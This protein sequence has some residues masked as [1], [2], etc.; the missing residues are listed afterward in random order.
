[1]RDLKI[2]TNEN[3][4][5]LLVT[6]LKNSLQCM[7]GGPLRDLLEK[8]MSI[9]TSLGAEYL[10]LRAQKIEKTE[11]LLKENK[12]EISTGIL[13]GIGIRALVGGRWGFSSVTKLDSIESGIKEAISMA[14]AS[15]KKGSI[16]LEEVPTVE[17]SVTVGRKVDLDPRAVTPEE[18]VSV[19]G[20]M[21]NK[22][23]GI[24]GVKAV[25]I[26][27]LD[28]SGRQYFCNSEG[29]YIEEDKTYVWTKIT[30]IGRKRDVIVTG[31]EEIGT[32]SGFSE[33]LD[34]KDR[35]IEKLGN[36]IEMQLES[37]APKGGEFPVVVGPELVGVL[38]HEAL[39]HLAEADLTLSG[40]IIRPLLGKKIASSLI[41]V[42][43]DGTI[44]GA[45]GSFFYD[46][47]G[48]PSQ[49]TQL[50]K[51]GKLVSLMYDR[52]H[53]MKF[54]RISEEEGIIDEFNTS[55]T[56]NARAESYSVPPIIRMSNTYVSKGDMSM[57]ELLEGIKFGYYLVSFRGGQA[58]L[59]GT[60][61][62]GVQEAY[63]ISNGEISNPVRS[64]SISGNTLETL[65]RVEGVGED[66]HLIS[67]RCGKG[68]MAFVGSG[69]PHLKIG[70]ILVG[71]A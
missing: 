42:Y 62:V 18:K 47:E 41:N 60:F 5:P 53:A 30:A 1:M 10:D 15:G 20:E 13:G 26:E 4:T 25:T 12:I 67:G 68:Q 51:E 8:F 69:G 24:Q 55:P 63:E 46:D 70:G 14:R 31:R 32:T 22:L 48:T 45:F 37:K 9:G 39:G 52:E 17:D 71:G 66:F 23:I 19:L 56:G 50:I 27:Y 58:N 38:V 44:E 6:Y 49:R 43:D 16:D 59:D 64:V 57:E 3:R 35:A 54:K 29:S 36:R 28:V 21:N 61:Q 7:L 40:S 2:K 33:F 11:V 34:K 65:N